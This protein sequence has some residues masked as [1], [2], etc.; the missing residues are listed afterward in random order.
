MWRGTMSIRDN[1]AKVERLA[2]VVEGAA[3]S[4]GLAERVRGLEDWRTAVEAVH[5]AEVLHG[6]AT[7]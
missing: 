4:V 6:K 5:Q 3:N 2:V 1:T 7:S